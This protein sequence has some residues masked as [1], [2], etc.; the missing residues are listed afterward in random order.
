MVD[1]L[2]YKKGSSFLHRT[3][4][5]V[6]MVFIPVLNILFLCLPPVFSVVLLCAQFI[7]ACALGFTLREQMND[8]RCIFWYAAM[9]VFVKVL[10]WLF[11]GLP[12]GFFSWEDWKETVLLLVKL[13]AVMQSASLVFRTS[14][15]LQMREG[16]GRIFGQRSTITNAI[17]MF[18]NFIPMVSAIWQ[19]SRRAWLARGGKKG[20]RMYIVLIPVLFSVGMKKAS[21]A[22]RAVS[23]RTAF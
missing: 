18:L 5:W 21:N 20:L 15:S 2:S 23:A 8:L 17:S 7:L 6:K 4:A 14:T 10:T 22:A 12:A 1:F 11:M 9:L 13:F 3:P 16:I 19:Q